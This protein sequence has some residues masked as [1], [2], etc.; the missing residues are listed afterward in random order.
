M[1]QGFQRM[2]QLIGLLCILPHQSGIVS[3]E[4]DE[5]GQVAQCVGNPNNIGHKLTVIRE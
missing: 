2:Q 5:V 4:V 3:I 1:N